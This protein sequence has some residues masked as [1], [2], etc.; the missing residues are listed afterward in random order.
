VG[1]VTRNPLDPRRTAGG[2]S[3]GAAAAVACGMAAF[4]WGSDFGGSI[5]QPAAYCGVRGMRL[6]SEAWP[7]VGMFPAPP[8][9]LLHLNG[10]GPIAPDL[11]TMR[12]VLAATAPS[13]RTGSARSFRL[14]G[15][16]LFGPGAR[17]AGRWPTFAR[18]VTP[19]LSEAAGGILAYPGLPS[20]LRALMVAAGMYCAHLEDLAACDPLGLSGGIAA[21]LSAVVFQGRLGDRR[22]HPRTAEV[23]LAIGAGRLALFRD[24]RAA[25]RDAETFRSE[26]AALWDRGYVIAAPVCTY[27]APRHGGAIRNPLLMTFTLPGNVADATA[28]AIPF[29]TFP[30]SG[31]PRS[32]QIWGPPGSEETLLDIGDRLEGHPG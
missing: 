8:A 21:A 2:S 11:R 26:V 10:Q 29:G 16:A 19:A 3:G 30:G 6:S 24:R 32:L 12:A 7:V 5:R 15:A 1:G 18:D 27:P 4:D 23:L 25:L 22:L 31:L 13:L 28:L 20:D 9:P 14:R 17:T